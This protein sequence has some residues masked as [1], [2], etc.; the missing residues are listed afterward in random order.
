M[1]ITVIKLI[2]NL[3]NLDIFFFGKLLTIFFINI[4][5]IRNKSKIF[6]F[7]YASGSFLINAYLKRLNE[8]KNK[9]D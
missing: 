2:N 3:K 9:L 1:V 4:I 6:W 8:F 5:I 7:D